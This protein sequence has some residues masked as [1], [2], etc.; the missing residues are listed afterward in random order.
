MIITTDEAPHDVTI[1]EI[2]EW[3]RCA[4]ELAELK[5]KELD[6]RK[7][8]F[9]GIF[10]DPVEGVNSHDLAHGYKLKGTHKLS[11]KIIESK[12][13]DLKKA[14]SDPYDDPFEVDIVTRVKNK[15]SSLIKY[16]PS[17]VQGEYKKLSDEE[18]L[19]FD[20]CLEIKPGTPALKIELSKRG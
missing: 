6:L 2:I 16:T 12:V 3:E 1:E 15:L 11:R 10:H 8:I 5:E 9:D 17:L 4:K 20:N 7:M 14:V 19:C 18:R 13:A